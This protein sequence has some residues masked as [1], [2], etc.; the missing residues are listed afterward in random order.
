M[1]SYHTI[2]L[3]YNNFFQKI[4]FI[5]KNVIDIYDLFLKKYK[6]YFYKTKFIKKLYMISDMIQLIIYY[7]ILLFF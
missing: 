2:G 1:I 5:L 7:F 6:Y 3:A 4:F